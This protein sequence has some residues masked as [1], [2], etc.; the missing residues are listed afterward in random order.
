MNKKWKK[1]K[2]APKDGTKF[3]AWYEIYASPM[4][5]GMSDE[6]EIPGVW[7]DGSKWVHMFRGKP[8]ELRDWYF[9]KWR[10]L[11]MTIPEPSS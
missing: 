9:T 8:T 5:F 2:S 4:S 7:W 10:P 11:D 1:F 6:F 3:N